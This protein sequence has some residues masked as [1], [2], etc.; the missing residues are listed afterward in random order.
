MKVGCF[1]L[2][3]IGRLKGRFLLAILSL[4]APFQAFADLS[5]SSSNVVGATP[6]A[7]EP[8]RASSTLTMV[9]G[10][11]FCLG[12]FAL[13]M[14]ITKRF[15]KTSGAGRRRRLEVRER[16]SLTSKTTLFLVAIDNREYLIANGSD[17]VSVTPTNSMT[18]PLFSES[19]EELCD[20]PKEIHA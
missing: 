16:L 18:T 1:T 2:N 8:S 3:Q 15:T 5:A 17:S 20:D 7:A 6:L 10:L 9:A 12:V 13:G 14:R 11:S 4:A 19:L